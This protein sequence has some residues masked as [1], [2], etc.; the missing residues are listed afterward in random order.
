MNAFTIFLIF[1]NI[2][3]A[4]NF[5]PSTEYNALED[6]YDLTGGDHWSW[7]TPFSYYG[8]PWNFTTIIQQNPCNSSHLWQG[9][10]CTTDCS[11][12]ECHVQNLTLSNRNLRGSENLP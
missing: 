10:Q 1:C 6:L 8:Y 5:L 4:A 3:G 9:I 2:L 12:S 7:F 11:V